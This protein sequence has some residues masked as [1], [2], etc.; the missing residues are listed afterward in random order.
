MALMPEILTGPRRPWTSWTF[1]LLSLVVWFHEALNTEKDR[2]RAS[3]DVQSSQKTVAQRLPHEEKI[4]QGN[5]LRSISLRVKSFVFKAGKA[6]SCKAVNGF[7]AE[8]TIEGLRL[9]S[10]ST[11]TYWC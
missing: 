4:P 6:V 3:A 9:T 7:N 11:L 8:G 1:S 5:A 10:P 2:A